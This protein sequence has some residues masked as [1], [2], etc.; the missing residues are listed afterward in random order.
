MSSTPS[1]IDATSFRRSLGN[2]ASGVTVITASGENGPV[3]MSANAFSA[4]SL[5]PALVSFCVAHTSTT[6]P[7]IRQIGRCGVNVLA[8]GQ[9]AL[10]R[11]FSQ[12]GIDRFAGLDYTLSPAGAPLLLG[13]LAW[14]DCEI[15]AEHL[16]GDHSIVVA[17]VLAAEV[18]EDR[19]PLLYFRGAFLGE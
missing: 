8:E 17:R 1:S 14:L 12:V 7:M 10:A 11:T 15:D 13:A 16:A 19:R 5:E 2:F 6:F 4:V 3:G 18:I 9:G